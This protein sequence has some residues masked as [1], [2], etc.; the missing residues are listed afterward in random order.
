MGAAY[1]YREVGP[2][3]L[4]LPSATLVEAARVA[5]YR[6]RLD[7]FASWRPVCGAGVEISYKTRYKHLIRL[8]PKTSVF[9]ARGVLARKLHRFEQTLVLREFGERNSDFDEK[10]NRWIH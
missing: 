3:L 4:R 10:N 9:A 5:R 8:C 2:G 1:V 7:E 6:L